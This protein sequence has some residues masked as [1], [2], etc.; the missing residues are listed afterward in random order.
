VGYNFLDL[1]ASSEPATHTLIEH[2]NGHAWKIQKGPN[3]GGH[4]MTDN[5]LLGV[6]ASSSTNMW[7]VG[8]YFNGTA[9]ETV[10]LHCR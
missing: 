10:A 8:S 5:Q 1:S 6:A 4:L 2:W 9:D 7:A 3:Q